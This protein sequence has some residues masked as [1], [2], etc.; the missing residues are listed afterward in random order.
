MISSDRNDNSSL[1]RPA[2]LYVSVQ[3]ESARD[4]RALLIFTAG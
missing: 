1:R 4:F 3:I 2:Q